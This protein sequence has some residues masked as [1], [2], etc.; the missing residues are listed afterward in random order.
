M[1]NLTNTEKELTA[2]KALENG[3]SLVSQALYTLWQPP[4]FFKL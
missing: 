3:C 4:F 2:Q 1:A